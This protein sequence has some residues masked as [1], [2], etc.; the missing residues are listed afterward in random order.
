MVLDDSGAMVETGEKRGQIFP[1]DKSLT[2]GNVER[3]RV[4]LEHEAELKRRF[5]RLTVQVI[6]VSRG[7]SR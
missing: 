6:R 1:I 4:R 2:F 3:L 5:D 7:K